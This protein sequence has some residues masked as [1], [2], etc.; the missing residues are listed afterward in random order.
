M[1]RNRS[2]DS[3]GKVHTGTRDSELK[4]RSQKKYCSTQALRANTANV[5]Q[6]QTSRYCANKLASIQRLCTDLS[7][8]NYQN[9]LKR[10]SR[11][12]LKVQ[13]H[14]GMRAGSQT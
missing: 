4:Y 13:R 6:H 2:L 10:P 8:E 14:R 7:L 5:T 11:A 1:G 12:A 3:H 9:H